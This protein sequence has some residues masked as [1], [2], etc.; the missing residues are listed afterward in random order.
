MAQHE[1]D[2]NAHHENANGADVRRS[3]VEDVQHL[4]AEQMQQLAEKLYAL[5]REDVR[6]TRAR[7]QEAPPRR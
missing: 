5:L 3:G 6:A 4:T 2:A 7:R 1:L